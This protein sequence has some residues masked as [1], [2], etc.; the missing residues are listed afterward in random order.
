M[1]WEEKRKK[2]CKEHL[3]KKIK[4]EEEINWYEG[5]EWKEKEKNA[6]RKI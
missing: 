3:K 2:K 5:K 1:A 4:Q 6:G